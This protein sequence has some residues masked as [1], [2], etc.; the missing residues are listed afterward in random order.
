MGGFAR[1]VHHTDDLISLLRSVAGLARQA[2]DPR[3]G[4]WKG[5]GGI[6]LRPGRNLA[7]APSRFTPPHT[8]TRVCCA[9]LRAIVL[10]H[11]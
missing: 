1:L 7:A 6:G 11:G 3:E 10:W 2:H 5:V 9:P 8:H 4:R